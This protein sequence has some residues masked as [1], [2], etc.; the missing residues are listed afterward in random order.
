MH[1][2]VPF[3]CSRTT[4][5]RGRRSAWFGPTSLKNKKPRFLR[6][7]CFLVA[8]VG[9]FRCASFT[10]LIAFSDRDTFVFLIKFTFFIFSVENFIFGHL[11]PSARYGTLSLPCLLGNFA[12]REKNNILRLFFSL[13]L[14]LVVE[15][16][17]RWF[18]PT[19]LKNK[20]PRFLRGFCFLVARV[21]FEPTTRGL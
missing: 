2:R 9:L 12:R 10:A 11:F 14:S 17:S 8:R 13:R 7:F 21:G 16:L 15:Q 5:D 4:F 19:S 20:K 3:A 18:G 1:F 6:G